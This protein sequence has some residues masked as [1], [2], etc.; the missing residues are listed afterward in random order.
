[1][2]CSQT[3]QA[4][5]RTRFGCARSRRP[6]ARCLR[7]RPAPNGILEAIF[8]RAKRSCSA[9]PSPL[10]YTAAAAAATCTC[11]SSCPLPL[12]SP[13][14]LLS[15]SPAP[16]AGRLRV[17]LR[18]H[19]S[20]FPSCVALM[21]HN[22]AIS[23]VGS[24]PL[25]GGIGDD[26]NWSQV[27]A[28]LGHETP[29]VERARPHDTGHCTLTRQST[30]AFSQYTPGAYSSS[31]HAPA[32]VPT[33]SGSVQ[34]H[35]R[36]VTCRASSTAMST[37]RCAGRGANMFGKSRQVGCTSCLYEPGVPHRHRHRERSP[38]AVGVARRGAPYRVVQPKVFR[39]TYNRPW[40]SDAN[41][42]P[43]RWDAAL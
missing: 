33:P 11:G 24:R 43:G 26:I 27:H 38:D 17:V 23:L 12:A 41:R 29:H 2:P 42:T 7:S 22:V 39:C 6:F 15:S 4:Q 19:P 13:R 36:G 20:L 28:V 3:H 30:C 34:L 14:F 31:L 37:A 35:L 25:R 21:L 1:V 16:P 9:R 8:R 5:H 32:P 40:G 18:P 10:V